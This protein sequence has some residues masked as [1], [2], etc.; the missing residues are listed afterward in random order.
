MA[1]VERR[2][3][4]SWAERSARLIPGC[5]VMVRYAEDDLWHERL[6]LHPAVSDVDGGACWVV[7]SPDG[8]VYIEELEGGSPDDSPVEWHVVVGAV[9]AQC[10]DVALDS[11]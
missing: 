7:M 5:R 6:L 3:P 10:G 9:L 11:G 8:D 1:L 4:G 2:G